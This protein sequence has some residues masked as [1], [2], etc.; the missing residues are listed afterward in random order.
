MTLVETFNRTLPSGVRIVT[1]WRFGT[2]VWFFLGARR[3]H[4]PEC[5]WRR[6]WPFIGPIP[7]TWQIRDIILSSAATAQI[8][9]R[10]RQRSF[11][12]ELKWRQILGHPLLKSIQSRDGSVNIPLIVRCVKDEAGDS[13]ANASNFWSISTV[14]EKKPANYRFLDYVCLKIN[15]FS[16]RK[17]EKV[18]Y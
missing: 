16:K 18:Y 3:F 1:V 13:R 8:I 5:G 4:A 15:S 17:W 2:N 12:F 11:K 7:D 6:L 14:I 10:L 9:F